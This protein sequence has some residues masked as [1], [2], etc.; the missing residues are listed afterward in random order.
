MPIR[1]ALFLALSAID[2]PPSVPPEPTA[3]MKPSILP[4]VCSQISGPVVSTW[5]RRLAVLSNWLAQIAPLGS[6]LSS[7]C[8]SL[9]ESRT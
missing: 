9:P 7:F 6:S 8:A 3:Q 4:C 2:T 5:A 1:T